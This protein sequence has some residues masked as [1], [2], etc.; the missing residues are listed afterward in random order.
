MLCSKEK[1]WE[2]IIE[3]IKKAYEQAKLVYFGHELNI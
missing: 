1:G 3:L 2:I